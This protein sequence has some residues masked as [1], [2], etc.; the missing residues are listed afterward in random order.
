MSVSHVD[1]DGEDRENVLFVPACGCAK[2]AAE[3][4]E[5]IAERT[6]WLRVSGR[7]QRLHVEALT[8]G[9][10]GTAMLG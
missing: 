3:A 2:C 8:L 4:L 1:N 10:R 7:T 5:A 9:E 6:S